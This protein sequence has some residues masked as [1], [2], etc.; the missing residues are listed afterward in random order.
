MNNNRTIN[1]FI[2]LGY[3]TGAISLYVL[4]KAYAPSNL[5]TY[6]VSYAL[7]GLPYYLV[8]KG[9]YSTFTKPTNLKIGLIAAGLFMIVVL[10]LV[11]Q[12]EHAAWLGALE[13]AVAVSLLL[14]FGS[15]LKR[16]ITNLM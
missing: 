6:L 4:T 3:I 9:I 2:A 13:S 14:E 8:M 16:A 10:S 15:V 5:N 7:G 11:V 1:L 12:S